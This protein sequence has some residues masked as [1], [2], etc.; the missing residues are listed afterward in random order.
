MSLGLVLSVFGC[1]MAT[2]GEVVKPIAK[3]A[4]DRYID[5]EWHGNKA[6]SANV[7]RKATFNVIDKSLNSL[8]RYARDKAVKTAAKKEQPVVVH[9]HNHNT[10]N[11]HNHHRNVRNVT[12]RV[13]AYPKETVR[14]R[15]HKTRKYHKG[16]KVHYRVYERDNDRRRERVVKEGEDVYIHETDERVS[17]G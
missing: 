8:I 13:E 10:Y 5:K 11:T 9:V 2:V 15:N 7:V 3:S 6:V 14:I 12:Y 1:N 16:K 17:L 4:A